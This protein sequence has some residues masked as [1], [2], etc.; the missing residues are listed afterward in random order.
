MSGRLV[1]APCLTGNKAPS[2]VPVTAFFFNVA[3]QVSP[4]SRLRESLV[5][6]RLREQKQKSDCDE[7]NTGGA[8]QL[9]WNHL[10]CGAVRSNNKQAKDR[11]G[12]LEEGKGKVVR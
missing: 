11:I 9:F 7:E 10:Y 5:E 1:F 2:R 4:G 6:D 12:G 8:L 3:S